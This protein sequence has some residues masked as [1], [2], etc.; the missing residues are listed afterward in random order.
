LE[1]GLRGSGLDL[2]IASRYI[3]PS[4]LENWPWTRLLFSRFANLVARALLGVPITDYTNGFRAYS[5]EAAECVTATCGRM[6]KGF[7]PL[8]E[9]LLNLHNRGYR[10]GETPTIFV[11][12]LRGESSVN[13]EELWNAASG[14]LR[15]FLRL[16][17]KALFFPPKNHR[18]NRR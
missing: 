7:I 12:R 4:N 13:T 6:G 17:M 18:S 15:I 10:I 16:R 8:S 2:L 1:K 9:T 5:R 3:P 14:V 11:N